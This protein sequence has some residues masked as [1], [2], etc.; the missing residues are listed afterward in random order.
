MGVLLFFLDDSL[1]DGLCMVEKGG[2]NEIGE[3]FFVDIGC[4]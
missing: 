4:C 1:A 2:C 3:L